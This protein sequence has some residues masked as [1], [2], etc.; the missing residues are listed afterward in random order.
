MNVF[1]ATRSGVLW[2][3]L[4][5]GL[6]G[7]SAIPGFGQGTVLRGS[8][9]D[10][11]GKPL[12]KAK[13]VLLDVERG[14]GFETQSN[15]KGEF[16][17]VGVPPA[18]YRITVELAGYIPYETAA[19]LKPGYE[20]R[21]KVVLRKIPAKMDDDKDFARGIALFQ[22]GRIQEAIE[23]FVKVRERFPEHV[24]PVYN[25]G[26]AY[27]RL[28]QAEKAVEAL[29]KAAELS[30][31][32]IEPLLAL[33][34]GYLSLGRDEQ[35]KESFAKAVSL[36]PQNPQA[37]FSLG[38]VAYKSD[39]IDEALASFAKAIELNPKFS[40]AH[41]QAGLA[42]AKKGDFPR[43]I[44]FFEKFLELDP[45]RP[46]AAQVRAMIDQ[47][48]KREAALISDAVSYRL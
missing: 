31:E 11:A 26:V 16:M 4:V 21:V 5:A 45:D 10:E 6:A 42:S 37:H 9:Q 46:E 3:T 40:A 27:L 33:G 15:K 17:Q 43:A 38:L 29:A 32:A 30:K 35:A 18:A 13:I 12:P 39:K 44:G 36:A 2:L 24:E 47:L 34:E 28:G 23:L 14:T 20:D 25:L 48:K 41:Y 7:I 8:V 19:S 22:E 1:K